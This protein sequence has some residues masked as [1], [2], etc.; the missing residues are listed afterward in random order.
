MK[1]IKEYLETVVKIKPLG[2]LTTK[3]D[4]LNGLSGEMVYIDGKCSDIFISHA[5]YANWLENKY[6][7]KSVHK[8][9]PK[10]KVG[11]W[12]ASD[13]NNVAY[14]ESISER[15]Y[16]LRCKDGYH[17]KISIEYIDRCWHLWSIKDAK[18]GDVLV[19]EGDVIAPEIPEFNSSTFIAIYKEQNGEYFNS[20][21]YVGLDG[22]FYKG[23]NGHVNEN[24]HP[25]TKEQRDML[26][27][28]MHKA[29]Y[30][31]NAEKK[32]MMKIVTPIFNIGDRIR[33]KGHA[34]DGVITEITDTDYICGD[35]KLPISTQ[36]KLELVGQ[37]SAEWSEDDKNIISDAEVWL[38]TLCDY[39]KDS[40]SAYIPN[41]RAIISKLKSLKDRVQPQSQWKPSDDQMHSL[42]QA[43]DSYTFEPDYLEEL[44]E[45]LKELKGE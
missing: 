13:Y 19:A 36:D 7:Q 37:K 16:N 14:I 11:D 8:V 26:F 28:K 41:V 35:T 25:A 20:H 2:E 17:E 40:S 45:D 23:Q 24:V 22:K 15:K 18:P 31:W 9:G 30:M 33:Y 43:I 29:G 3:E 27:K 6:E 4:E 21:C 5:D 34:C 42:K 39:L 12:V 32:E 1:Y 44:Y 10:F 38:D